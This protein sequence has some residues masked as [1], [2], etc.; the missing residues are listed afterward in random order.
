[1]RITWA[2]LMKQVAKESRTNPHKALITSRALFSIILEN[3]KQGHTVL[4]PRFGTFYQATRP[5]QR[6]RD[7]TNTYDPTATVWVEPR[8]RVALRASRSPKSLAKYN[9]R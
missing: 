7:L 6:V 8:K 2:K 1:M 5:G 3:V 4:V 9:K